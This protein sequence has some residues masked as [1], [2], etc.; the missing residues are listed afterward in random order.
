MCL[1]SDMVR[2]ARLFACVALGAVVYVAMLITTREKMVL[3]ILQSVIRR[4]RW[5]IK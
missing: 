3:G 5:M 4:M 1:C 2:I